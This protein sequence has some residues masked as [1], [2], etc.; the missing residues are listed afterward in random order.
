[1]AG[2]RRF[3]PTPLTA[4]EMIA[5]DAEHHGNT[6]VR[7]VLAPTLAWAEHRRVSLLGI[8]HPL[9]GQEH[10][11]SFAGSAAFLELAGAAYSIIPD[12]ASDEPIVK[13]KPRIMVSAK[14]NLAADNIALSYRI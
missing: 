5:G 8:C 1:M 13:R 3:R 7:D 2:G 12:P 14:A 6:G 10:K 9:K 4:A 11:E